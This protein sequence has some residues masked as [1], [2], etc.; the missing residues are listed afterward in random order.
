MTDLR[1]MI[2]SIIARRQAVGAGTPTG[3]RFSTL[4]E[5]IEN[6]VSPADTLAELD[7]LGRDGGEFVYANHSRANQ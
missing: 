1:S 3:R 5:Q 7:Q 4:I 6:G 2:P